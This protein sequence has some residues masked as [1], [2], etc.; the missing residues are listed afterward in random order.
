MK[1]PFDQQAD[2][3]THMCMHASMQ[4]HSDVPEF[5]PSV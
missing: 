3:F 5:D 1:M 2:K 4:P